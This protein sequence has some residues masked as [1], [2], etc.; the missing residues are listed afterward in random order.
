MLL[1]NNSYNN[2]IIS[3]ADGSALLKSNKEAM[4]SLSINSLGF[5]LD[6]MLYHKVKN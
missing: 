5:S 6:Q 4:E 2:N 3:T 1:V